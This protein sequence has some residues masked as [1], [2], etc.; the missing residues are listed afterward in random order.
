MESYEVE[1][2]GKT[3]QGTSV[4]QKVTGY[5]SMKFRTSKN[6]AY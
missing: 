5:S 4:G 3:Y 6:E 2:N 1:I